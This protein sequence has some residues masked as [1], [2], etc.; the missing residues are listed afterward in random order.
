M[1]AFLSRLNNFRKAHP[2][3]AT[4]ILMS[5]WAVILGF[6]TELQSY[7]LPHFTLLAAVLTAMLFEVLGLCLLGI[8]KC[9][10]HA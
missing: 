6:L 8:A 9:L 7:G 10:D 3:W 4:I 1:R 2:W 5:V